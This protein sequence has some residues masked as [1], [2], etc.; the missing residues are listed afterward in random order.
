M[1]AKIIVEIGPT[2]AITA[3]FEELINL[4]DQ[5]TKKEGITVEELIG[6]TKPDDGVQA[7][8]DEPEY[9]PFKDV[10][11]DNSIEVSTPAKM[12]KGKA[13]D[14]AAENINL[15]F[16]KSFIFLIISSLC[17]KTKFLSVG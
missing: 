5:E 11:D 2:A 7:K 4:I 6:P 16:S 15:K 17:P 14:E 12:G 8:I 3:K 9:I 13:P 10:A 1:A